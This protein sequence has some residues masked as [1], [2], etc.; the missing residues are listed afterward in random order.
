MA[1]IRLTKIFRFEMAH[2]LWN[3]DGKCRNIHGHSYRLEVTVIGEPMN[4]PGHPK[5]GMVMDF[6]DLKRIVNEYIIDRHDHFLTINAN[7]PHNEV[8]YEKFG[9]ELIQRKQY[10]PTSE[11]MVLEFVE[12]LK[13]HLPK[14][15]KLYSLRLYETADS[16]AEW[17]ADDNE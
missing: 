11:N 10:Q 8:E 9:F 3:Y 13:T 4:N 7:S 2:A 14:H 5:D 17:N 12:I 6:G 1:K 16:Y 15:I